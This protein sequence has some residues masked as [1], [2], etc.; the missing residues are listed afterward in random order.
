[1]T[2]KNGN[3]SVFYNKMHSEPNLTEDIKY[4]HLLK[5]WKK[6]D[7]TFPFIDSRN[8]FN[9]DF[10]GSE[11]DSN[12]KPKIRNQ[13][14]HSKNIILFLSSKTKNSKIL[15]EEI[16]YAIN[17]LGLPI[18]VIYPEYSENNK[19]ISC[20]NEIFKKEIKDL[21]DKLPIFEKSMHKIPTFHI[22]LN[23][24]LVRN[25]LDDRD[26]MVNTKCLPGTFIYQ[27]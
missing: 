15:Q 3:Y 26:F 18:I 12:I 1:M 19:I 21:W 24:M 14:N 25:A 20:P 27:C 6:D 23:K 11:W 2:Y 10:N 17:K 7:S 4:Y 16:D 8:K 5:S 9:D 13:L 22:P